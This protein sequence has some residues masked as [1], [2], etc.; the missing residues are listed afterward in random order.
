M[1]LDSEDQRKVLLAIIAEAPITGK[2]ARVIVALEEAVYNAEIEKQVNAKK[3]LSTNQQ[4]L[5]GKENG[6]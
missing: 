5:K 6:N 3:E 1:K 4:V 2:G